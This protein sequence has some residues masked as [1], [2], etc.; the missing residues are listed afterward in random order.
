METTG[1]SRRTAL[2]WFLFGLVSIP[3]AIW[4]VWGSRFVHFMPSRADYY[5]GSLIGLTLLVIATR[6]LIQRIREFGEPEVWDEQGPGVFVGYIIR[7]IVLEIISEFSFQTRNILEA[8]FRNIDFTE[9]YAFQSEIFSYRLLVEEALYVLFLIV[10][11]PLFFMLLRTYLLA[12]RLWIAC[13]LS[14][15]SGNLSQPSAP[16]KSKSSSKAPP[17]EQISFKT[18]ADTGIFRSEMRG[19]LSGVCI[20]ATVVI[21][22]SLFQA[23]FQSSATTRANKLIEELE[24][25]PIAHSTDFFD[26]TKSLLSIAFEL[27]N[28]SPERLRDSELTF[29]D[30]GDATREI[31]P[32]LR[33]TIQKLQEVSSIKGEIPNETKKFLSDLKTLKT[34][35]GTVSA[36]NWD[37]IVVRTAIILLALVAVR[38]FHKQMTD[39]FQERR[40]WEAKMST[41]RLLD[42]NNVDKGSVS[43][44]TEILK[45]GLP[46]AKKTATESDLIKEIQK[47]SDRL[48]KIV[49]PDK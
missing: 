18:L 48:E 22:F 27:Q 31:K 49:S 11:L 28:R 36:T 3:S 2:N 47:L 12:I 1:D 17:A 15:F 39:A 13:G 25:S 34:E 21:A 35:L 6:W 45:S 33:E 42:K 26:T 9:I 16:K 29:L 41:L 32:Y 38:I 19:Y 44:F 7:I 14:L 5:L 43:D 8:Y 37:I 46:E 23:V 10:T 24:T 20:V 4:I 30:S 40:I